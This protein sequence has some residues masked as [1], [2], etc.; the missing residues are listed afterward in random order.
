MA[1]IQAD[2]YNQYSNGQIITTDSAEFNQDE[3]YSDLGDISTSDVE[4]IKIN[5]VEFDNTNKWISL[6]NNA[7][8]NAP[9]FMIE[10]GRLLV[11]N[12][13]LA[14]LA[15]D[16]IA[17]V[18]AG[19]N[20]YEVTLEGLDGGDTLAFVEAKGVNTQEGKINEVTVE[21]S[22]ITQ[23]S[24]NGLHMIAVTLE[25]DGQKIIDAN[26]IIYALRDNG[27]LGMTTPESIGNNGEMYTYGLYMKYKDGDYEAADVGEMVQNVTLIVL[28]KG[29]IELTFVLNAQEA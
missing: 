17:N 18:E 22:T 4:S 26:Q 14:A 16:G 11:A 9:V 2:Y 15:Q 20:V 3:L 7:W 12:L 13:Y 27:Q 24:N 6:G 23:V 21:D 10:E 1:A 25:A 29:N 19:K 28:G 5:G 8:M